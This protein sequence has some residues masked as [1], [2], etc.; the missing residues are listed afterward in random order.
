MNAKNDPELS[1]LHKDGESDA[2]SSKGNLMCGKVIQEETNFHAKMRSE[3]GGKA[4]TCPGE[5]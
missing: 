2:L 1:S 4:L 3:G 5:Y